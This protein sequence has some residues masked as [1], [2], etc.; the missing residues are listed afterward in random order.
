[1]GHTAHGMTS[2]CTVSSWDG[3]FMYCQLMGWT[4]HVLSAH[5]MDSS[6][7]VSSWDGQ[8]M[9]CQLL[10]WKVH[11]LS[12]HYGYHGFIDHGQFMYCQLIGWTVHVLSAHGM[13]SSCTV[14]SWE[15]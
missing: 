10:G 13:E 6:C 2:S 14:S 11:V 8:F 12:A 4:V 15:G 9:Y 5:G 1:M 7:T 3:Q